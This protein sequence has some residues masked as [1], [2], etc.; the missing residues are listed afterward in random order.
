MYNFAGPGEI[1]KRSPTDDDIAGICNA[2]PLDKNPNYCE[3][4][5]LLRYT[6]RS[7]CTFGTRAAPFGVPIVLFAIALVGI[8]IKRR[9]SGT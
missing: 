4:T 6:R 5:D 7:G 3:H 8:R 9:R 1:K 2:Y